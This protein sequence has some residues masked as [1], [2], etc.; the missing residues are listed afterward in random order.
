MKYEIE[1]EGLP[2]G[3]KPVAYRRPVKNEHYLSNKGIEI[4]SY[5]LD[6]L[7][8]TVERIKP[9]KIILEETTE[10]MDV[11]NISQN[12]VLTNNVG[13]EVH[14]IIRSK[15]VWKEVKENEE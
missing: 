1:I 7:W 6:N 8:L 2:E 14:F 9:R 10:L 15:Y 4:T 11:K 5:K 3:W 12:I 13:N